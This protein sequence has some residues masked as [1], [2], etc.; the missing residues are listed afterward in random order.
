MRLTRLEQRLDDRHDLFE[1]ARVE[2]RRAL[3]DAEVVALA[4]PKQQ[5]PGP[6][7]LCEAS[8]RRVDDLRAGADPE[9]V[10]VELRRREGQQDGMA[11]VAGASVQLVMRKLTHLP[12]R[13][14]NGKSRPSA[15]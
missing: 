7:E 11:A 6:S 5:R 12:T 1:L 9:R 14:T 10:V 3:I 4:V 2:P 13:L 8:E 15:A